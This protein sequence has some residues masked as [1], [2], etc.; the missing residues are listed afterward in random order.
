MEYRPLGGESTLASGP[1]YAA[2][3]MGASNLV[4]ARYYRPETGAGRT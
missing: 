3:E 4:R 1:R 2:D